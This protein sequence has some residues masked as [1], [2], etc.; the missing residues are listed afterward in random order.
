MNPPNI[1]PSFLPPLSSRFNAVF[2]LLPI[3]MLGVYDMDLKPS[4]VYR[5]PQLYGPCIRNEWFNPRRF[6]GWISMAMVES[7]LQSVLPM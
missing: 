7:V 4:T 6:W 3:I 2:T 1:P 5:F